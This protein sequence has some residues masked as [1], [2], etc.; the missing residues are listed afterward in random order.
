MKAHPAQLPLFE[1][2]S[3]PMPVLA[4]YDWIVLSSSA[5]KDSQCMIDVVCE[6]AEREGCLSRVVVVHADLGRVEWQGTRELA[7]RQAAAY[8]L[9][10]VAVWRRQGDLLKEVEGRGKWPGPAT[11]FCTAHHKTN[12][13]SR[14]LTQ[15]TQ[16][17]TNETQTGAGPHV[18]AREGDLL[19]HVEARGMWPDPARRWC[20]SDHNRAH[21]HRLY[22]AMTTTSSRPAP[23]SLIGPVRILSCMG[24]RADESPAR[25]KR[26]PLV[27]NAAASNGKR[28]VDDWLP[29][30]H[31]TEAE[32][33]ERI[34]S[35]R[36][37]D[38]VHPAYALGM[39]R[40]SCCFCIFAPKSA[41]M[42]AGRHNPALLDE[43][44]AV[45]AR[46]GHRFRQELSMADVKAA[47]VA[48]EK[49]GGVAAWTM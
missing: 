14:V 20:T 6:Q 33:W 41:L 44:V 45:E 29:L 2:P 16:E 26:Q 15:L 48:G 34:R 9:R 25:A 42:L 43:Y 23:K 28:H 35:C 40:L 32:V 1:T 21:V 18:E 38:M 17:T 8:G 10:F 24:M 3:P 36:Q 39:P 37:A 49:T 27:R 19:A 47:I 30:H 13:V 4:D 12:Q 7:E 5:G 31:W 22:T 11:R 46:I